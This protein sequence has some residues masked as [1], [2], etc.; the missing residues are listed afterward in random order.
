MNNRLNFSLILLCL[1]LINFKIILINEESLILI[2]F[3]VFCF[4]AVSRLSDSTVE[5][6]ENQTDDI[7]AEFAISARQLIN[8]S[9]TKKKQ[10]HTRLCWPGVFRKLKIEFKSFNIFI[11]G[12]FSFFYNSQLQQKIQKKLEFSS[13][14]ESQ[15]TKVLILI[16]SEK[17]QNFVRLQN[18]CGSVLDIPAFKTIKKIYF[19]EHLQKLIR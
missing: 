19:R 15:L 18:F 8:S 7:K 14:L 6:F 12:Q 1:V 10:L 5:F 17:L 3:S 9:E 2:C 4:L 13:R 16:I 11:L